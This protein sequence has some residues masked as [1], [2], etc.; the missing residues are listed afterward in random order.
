MVVT[1]LYFINKASNKARLK[2]TRVKL[3]KEVVKIV[4]RGKWHIFKD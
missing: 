4:M 1:N 2:D 3:D